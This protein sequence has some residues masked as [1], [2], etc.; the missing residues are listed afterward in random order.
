MVLF[1]EEK[2]PYRCTS[3]CINNALRRVILLSIGTVWLFGTEWKLAG[4]LQKN[5][6]TD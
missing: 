3:G 4:A 2:K 6:K 5:W 1:I